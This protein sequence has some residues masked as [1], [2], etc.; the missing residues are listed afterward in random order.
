[1]TFLEKQKTKN[2]SF[3]NCVTNNG[4]C[5]IIFYQPVYPKSIAFKCIWIWEH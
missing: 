2:K 1:M 3:I 5:C 4:T